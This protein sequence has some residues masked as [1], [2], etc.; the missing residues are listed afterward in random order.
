MPRRKEVA[1]ADGLGAL[2]ADSVGQ[3]AKV[4]CYLLGLVYRSLSIILYVVVAVVFT[5]H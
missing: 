5:L 4:Q 3:I 1:S 2:A